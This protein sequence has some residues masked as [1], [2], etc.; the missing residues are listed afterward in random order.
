VGLHPTVCLLLF[1]VNEQHFE[2]GQYEFHVIGRVC[3]CGYRKC[4]VKY[5]PGAI[6]GVLTSDIT[7]SAP[8]ALKMEAA[9]SSEQL[10]MVYKNT[11]RHIT[12]K[13]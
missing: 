8:Y 3:V 2:R 5:L 11:R 13:W 6:F 7:Q 12:E 9:D 10:V 1:A 4:S